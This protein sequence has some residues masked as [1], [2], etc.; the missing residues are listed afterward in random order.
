[1]ATIRAV[2]MHELNDLVTLTG[3]ERLIVGQGDVLHKIPLSSKADAVAV[4]N[5]LA[6]KAEL[7]HAHQ[8]TDVAGLQAALAAA[9]SGTTGCN[10][11][12]SDIAS[13]DGYTSIDQYVLALAIITRY[14][15]PTIQLPPTLQPNGNYSINT[16][17]V[18]VITNFDTVDYL[19]A[20]YEMLINSPTL[21]F[22][23]EDPHI[24]MVNGA[25]IFTTSSEVGAATI[26]LGKRVSLSTGWEPGVKTIN[27][28]VAAF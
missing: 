17:Y 27:I 18:L 16:Q 15:I 19:N 2:K 14:P 11:L 24:D 23:T 25:V 6:A 10:C 22:F 26:D 7:A 13:P 21:T 12:A 5:A 8:I 28:N 1:M 4:S 20:E 3:D 9:G